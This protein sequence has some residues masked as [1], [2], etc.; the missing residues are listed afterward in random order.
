MSKHKFTYA[1]RYAVW[2]HHGSKCYWCDEPL[3]IQETTVDHFIPEYLE[4]KPTELETV[5]SKYSLSPGF[6]INDYCNWLPSHARCNSVSKGSRLPKLTFQA[7]ATLDK[8]AQDAE[9]VRSIEIGLK[10]KI[11]ADKR[12]AEV[13][14]RLE[15]GIQHDAFTN[16]QKEEMRLLLADPRFEQD[17]DIQLLRSQVYLDVEQHY[18]DFLNRTP[19]P[20]SFMFWSNEIKRS[21][22]TANIDV[23]ANVSAAFFLSLEFYDSGYLVYRMYKAAFGSAVGESTLPTK[24]VLSVPIIRLSEF[25]PAIQ[26][27]G[28]GV[29]VGEGEW[30]QQLE[31]NKAQF[32]SEFVSR[33]RF[34][35]GYP[36]SMSSAQFV[37]SL[38]MNAGTPLNSARR[39]QLVS[40]LESGVKT[41]A[42]LLRTVVEDPSLITSEYNR[43]FVLMQYFGYLR[44]DP[45]APPDSDYT[46]YEFWL[47][48]LNSFSGNYVAAEMVKA[49]IA[50]DEYK[51][52][53]GNS[54]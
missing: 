47:K 33:S 29:I 38:N 27:I 4:S 31:S 23:L 19:D 42:Q 26:Q 50:S 21:G 30:Q 1:Q 16:E 14:V 53:F 24:H 11:K 46:G 18:F 54:F 36:N 2:K 52:R 28:Q 13:M 45:N 7:I 48:K 22:S 35:L 25:I 12:F 51:Q 43:A 8:L 17:E 10:K 6:V 9:K 3:G 40:E 5:R 44:R 37:D 41:R 20:T 49:F 34:V 39:D 15:A 32:M